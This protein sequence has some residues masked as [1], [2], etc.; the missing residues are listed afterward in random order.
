MYFLYELHLPLQFFSIENIIVTYSIFDLFILEFLIILLIG[1]LLIRRKMIFR[2]ALYLFCAG[3][4]VVY[5]FQMISVN[6]GREF[7]S[8]LAVENMDHIYLFINYKNILFAVLIFLVCFMLPVLI[9]KANANEAAKTGASPSVILLLLLLIGMIFIGSLWIPQSIADKRDRYL[10]DSYMSHSS[11]FIAFCNVLFLQEVHYSDKLLHPNFKTFEFD[12]FKKFGF[13]YDPTKEYPLIKEKIYSG[14]IPFKQKAEENSAKPNIIVIFVEG[15][16]AR[17]VGTYGSKFE[18]L[19]PNID[20]FA[21]SSMIVRRYYNH[22]AATYR[23]LHGQLC[24]LYPYFGGMG[25]WQTNYKEVAG[26]RYL[27]L[28]NLFANDGYETIF[29]DSHHKNHRSRVDEMITGLGFST[30]VT[31]DILA[32][33]Y[34]QKAAPNLENAYSDIQYFDGIIGYLKDRTETEEGEKPFF[35]SLYNFGTHAFLHGSKDSVKYGKGNNSSLNNFHNLDRGFGR[36]WNYLK[37]SPYEDNT[38]LILTAD[39]CH[40]PEKPY[41]AAFDEPGFQK[42]FVDRIPLIIHDPTRN[43]PETYD[44]GNAS[45][46]DFAPTLAHY[47]GMDNVRN[48]FLG[49]SI[50]EAGRKEYLHFAVSA[51]GPREIFLIDQDRIHKLGEPGKYRSRIKVLDKYIGVVKQLELDDRIWNE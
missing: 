42:I 13:S 40:Y 50:F 30:V 37:S 20:D 9:E 11:P 28:A 6:N 39:H 45:S 21:A 7:L 16:S 49:T 46:I 15:L 23:G 27:S 43:L 19:T 14:E 17:A 32:D 34:L 18:N 10:L 2:L 48:P 5:C 12:E 44:A 3:F 31:G 4:I 47:L 8:R 26:K 38:I 41:V 35:M 1:E 36:L 29:L 51:I 24:S 33:K 25:G 22:T